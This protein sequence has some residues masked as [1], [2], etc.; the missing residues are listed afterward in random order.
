MRCTVMPSDGSTRTASL[1]RA[2]RSLM[3]C[4]S[5]TILAWP[6]RH[7]N[8]RRDHEWTTGCNGSPAA[9]VLAVSTPRRR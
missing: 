7:S 9:R 5:R 3:P 2:G 1:A 8:R 4:F 6:S